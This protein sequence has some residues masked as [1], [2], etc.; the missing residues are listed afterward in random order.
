MRKKNVWIFNFFLVLEN[1]KVSVY[2]TK[3]D[4][5]KKYVIINGDYLKYY[6]LE[7]DLS[8]L[9][10]QLQCQFSSF[11]ISNHVWWCIVVMWILI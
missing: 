5:V 10:N 1:F 7:L 2:F 3:H 11:R 8:A 6:L 9:Q 4:N